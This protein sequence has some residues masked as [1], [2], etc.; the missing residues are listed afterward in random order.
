[1]GQ[2]KNQ[3]I[4]ALRGIAVA[5]AVTSHGANLL[6]WMGD[7]IERSGY[8]FWAGVDVFFAISGFVIAKAFADRLGTWREIAAFFVRRAFRLLP[9]SWLWLFVVIALS[10]EFNSTWVFTTPGSNISDLW[11]VVLNVSNF[12]FA[13]CY[14]DI[15]KSTC[16]YNGQYWSLSLEE[17]FYLLFPLLI[18]LP[19]RWFMLLSV[20]TVFAWEHAFSFIP[21]NDAT[22]I[23]LTRVSPIFL[24]VCI[25]R[26]IGTRLYADAE[27]VKLAGR[28]VPVVLVFALMKSTSL[29]SVSMGSAAIVWI[30]SYGR[31]YFFAPCTIR[32]VFEWLG[33]RSFAVYLIHNP[34]FWFTREL[35][36]R[37]RP[38]VTF[39][40]HYTIAFL[41]TAL[42]LLLL[43]A[44]INY[45]VVETPLRD[46]GARLANRFTGSKQGRSS[47][48][49]IAQQD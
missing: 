12:H 5:L 21:A 40:H 37:I 13:H 46:I 2:Q 9:T 22:Y 23:Y 41:A 16:G 47:G 32:R 43:L 42:P 44:E 20:A 38:G 19:R 36:S 34:V 45:R 14:E 26:L 1:M 3:E 10:A 35:W 49:S 48:L 17:Q 39:D 15:S 11:S 8:S 6:F 25:A 4:E 29:A 30:A 7:S 24:G 33:A 18:L 31:G 27:P 28:I